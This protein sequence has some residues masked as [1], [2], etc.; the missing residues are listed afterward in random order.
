MNICD[1]ISKRDYSN[2]RNKYL[3]KA[4]SVENVLI[5]MGYSVSTMKD[6]VVVIEENNLDQSLFDFPYGSFDVFKKHA[7]AGEFDFDEKKHEASQLHIA[8]VEKR[9]KDKKL[10][11]RY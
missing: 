1:Y 3:L 7:L 10:W 9:S 8:K 11:V 2:D 5:N 6:T 4:I